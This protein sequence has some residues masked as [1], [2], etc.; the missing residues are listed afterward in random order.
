MNMD[1][2]FIAI[3]EEESSYF[4][5]IVDTMLHSRKNE[6][7]K[8]LCTLNN[9]I[10][11][12]VSQER[13]V[14]GVNLQIIHIPNSPD[15]AR[16]LL[17]R[18]LI[19]KVAYSFNSNILNKYRRA[20]SSPLILPAEISQRDI[21]KARDRQKYH[22]AVS[23]YFS[24]IDLPDN[25]SKSL[26]LL[27]EQDVITRK[28]DRNPWLDS[29]YSLDIEDEHH[30]VIVSTDSSDF[31]EA[32]IRS[33][34]LVPIIENVFIFHSPNRGNV[35]NFYN[36]DQIKRLNQYGVGIKNCIVLSFSDEPQGLYQVIENTKNRLSTWLLKRQMRK[37]DDFE[38][39]ITFTPY[40]ID[41][42]FNRSSNQRQA[43][44]D[45]KDRSYF[46]IEL[47][48]I[49]EQVPHHLKYKNALALAMS[50]DLQQQFFCEVSKE[51]P[52]LGYEA[53]SNFFTLSR[54]L[55]DNDI[56][57]RI[58]RFLGGSKNVAFIVP[59][60]TSDA[61]RQALHSLF[62]VYGRQINFYS[63]DEMKKGIEEE[64][65]IVLQY[66]YTEKF[67]KSYPNSYDQ[68]PLKTY[69]KALV[70]I[71]LLTHNNYYEWNRCRYDKDYN[72]LLY[73]TFRKER[74][75]WS[76]K[77]FP[78]P[79]IPDI[80]DYIDE[81]EADNREYMVEKCSIQFIGGKSR[82][83]SACERVL[84]EQNEHYQVAEI[85]EITPQ[86][87]FDI[88]ILDDLGEQVKSL[89]SKKTESN[90]DSERI[91]K[92][93]EIYGLSQNEID[94]SD[95]L[96]RIL[97]RRKVEQH[98]IK[99]MYNE[100]IA[101][102]S[103]ISLN[104]FE[105]WVNL[106][107]PMILPRSRKD[108]RILLTFL[109]FGLGSPYHRIILAKKLFNINNSRILNGQVAALLQHILTRDI[110]QNFESCMEAHSDIMT[111]LDVSS[112]DDV[113]TLIDLLDIELKPAIRIK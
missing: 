26:F 34:D 40:E 88:Q 6:G 38:G 46:T 54:Q 108:Q 9:I 81:A 8:Y 59:L 5:P 64:K 85:R 102:G 43:I 95:E 14:D 24:N 110:A 51:I 69:Q 100:F 61:T 74:L 55:W 80:R 97:L 50:D 94:S 22:K 68:L 89:I 77:N 79:S 72:G 45:Y 56:R 32:K 82:E 30:N 62:Y 70:I 20:A 4:R 29:L 44:I 48:S 7:R 107:I 18:F 92:S 99:K 66:R 1:D 65:I 111:L 106:D 47:D 76:K 101:L 12:C 33:I 90:A 36:I 37:Y 98:G 19:H 3:V 13:S 41:F 31:L 104:G 63:I 23:K 10:D 28:Q 91:I 71:N 112:I 75:G 86:E 83:Y 67:Y 78:Q 11:W 15:W 60:E 58:N 105:R 49:L 73:S 84:Y 53:F 39:F 35:V 2:R 25:S 93:D 52:D 113:F 103:E 57:V 42:L 87:V 27:K 16:E 96:W 109:G 17:V 21:K